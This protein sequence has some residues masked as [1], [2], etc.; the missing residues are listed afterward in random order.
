MLISQTDKRC[1]RSSLRRKRV[2]F[3]T[4]RGDEEKEIWSL[5]TKNSIYL[6]AADV[7]GQPQQGWEMFLSG[8]SV[9]H[10]LICL[11]MLP[12]IL[13]AAPETLVAPAAIQ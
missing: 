4:A 5:K 8:M 7:R 2:N 10:V 1:E 9:K 6:C 3:D 13:I 12:L 11:L